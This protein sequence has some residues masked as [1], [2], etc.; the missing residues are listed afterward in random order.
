MNIIVI[1]DIMIDINNYCITNRKAAEANIPIYKI[2][3][4]EYKLGGAANVA[5][6]LLN[7]NI[8]LISI[9]GNDYYGKIIIELLDKLNINNK[10]F[11]DNKRKTTQ[12]NRLFYD[13]KLINRHDIEDDYDINLDLENDIFNYIK[14]IKDID[15][16]VLSDY[17]KGL[18]TFN[19]CQQIINFS[20]DNNIYTFVDPK[21]KNIMK[22]KNCFCLKP[23]M[24]E[25]IQLT[26]ETNI[27][28]IFNILFDK[29]NVKNIII[30]NAEKGLYLNNHNN[31]INNN[32]KFNVIDVT[33]AGDI[34]LSVLLICYLQN[35]NLILSSKIANYIASKSIE[36]IGNYK[37]KLTDIDEY[38]LNENKIIYENEKDKLELLNKLYSNIIFTNGC[39]DIFHSA[40]LRLLNYCKEQNG[41][42]ILGL[43]S[44]ISIK[45]IKGENRPINNLNERIEL[46]KNLNIIDYIIIFDDE[47]PYNIL[48]YLKPNT[49]VKGGDYNIDN[50]IGKEFCN[51]IKLFNYINGI[52]TTNIIKHIFDKQS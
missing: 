16:I 5:N 28:N 7:N 45:K 2:N 18:L 50:I 24:N 46:L 34:F 1:G 48:K 29:L 49:I 51:E 8:K 10:L 12:K 35:N 3:K 4:T 43:N 19:L 17:D 22:Y 38:Y 37:I 39:F 31:I 15:A 30:T 11:I 27:N 33:G 9:I 36:Y 52:S 23:N 44:D 25:S 41:T 42:V 6:N 26:N 21:I 40:H 47:T 32:K 20:N 13:N 14:N